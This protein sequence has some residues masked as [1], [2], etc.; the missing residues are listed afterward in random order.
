[1][2]TE[3]FS[4]RRS[5]RRTRRIQPIEERLGFRDNSG[6][7][8]VVP[9]YV[10]DSLIGGIGLQL[11]VPL[12]QQSLVSIAVAG[13]ASEAGD[14]RWQPTARVRWWCRALAGGVYRAG[15]LFEAAQ[16][17]PPRPA[18]PAEEDFYELLQISPGASPEVI[19]RV[20]GILARQWDPDNHET[21]D[22]AAFRALSAAYQVLSD[23]A[24][25]A[26]YDAQHTAARRHRWQ[27]FHSPQSTHGVEAERRKRLGILRALYA[28]RLNECSSPEMKAQELEQPPGVSREHL[29]F[30][31]WYL[32]ERG[33][34]TRTDNTRY[35]ITAAGVEYAESLEDQAV[36]PGLAALAGRLL[37]AAEKSK[38]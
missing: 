31:L 38:P 28:K 17:A 33:L 27:I 30:P 4:E 34:L 19:H 20:Y 35:L 10:V 6:A 24:R 18:M 13:K 7:E 29:E 37:P 32:R 5:K 12:A 8:R 2:A 21:G 36:Q 1:M 23:P 11:R 9:A 25:R 22:A 15:L 3:P 26:A 14:I 16:A